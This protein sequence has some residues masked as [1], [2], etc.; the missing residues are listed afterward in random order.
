MLQRL[1]RDDWNWAPTFALVDQQAAEIRWSTLEQLSR[2]KRSDRSKAELW[3]LF[4]ASML[5]RG[6]ASEDADAVERFA[7]RIT[8]M[9]G[10]EEW[11]DAYLAPAMA[12]LTGAEL[13][14]ELLNLMRWRLEKVLGYHVT[15]S[16]EMKNTRGAPVYN[17]VFATDHPAG[18][19]IMNHIY[20]KAAQVRPQMQAEAAAKLQEAKEEESG[21][22][23]CSHPSRR[24]SGPTTSTPTSRPGRPIGYRPASSDG[25]AG[26]GISSQVRPSSSRP[27]CLG[28]RP[29]HCLKKNGTSAAQAVITDARAPTSAVIGRCRD[30][31]RRRR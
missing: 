28:V 2:F 11:R 8:A 9:Y 21:A 31:T 18:E 5:P 20:G 15:H 12:L 16:F 27:P 25:S 29:P 1:T 3:L 4:A 14:D 22:P 7:D 19:R 13:R 26:T 30:R 6:L 10:T 24:Q 23:G 17:M